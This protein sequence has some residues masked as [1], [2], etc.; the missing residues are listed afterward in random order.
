MSKISSERK[1][2]YYVG[3]GM[4]VLGFILFISVF[5]SMA[6]FMSNPFGEGGFGFSKGPSFINAIIGIILMIVGSIVMNIGARGAAGAGIILDPDKAREDLKPYSE[7]T[8]G[9]INDVI[10]NIDVVDK[11]TTPRS[12]KEVIKIKCRNCGSLNDE[13]AKYC[14]S[15]GKEI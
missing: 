15:C 13:D 8:G 10:S 5:F 3:L 6:S 9:M 14:K 2:T 4:I 12:E 11:I 1:A 7:A